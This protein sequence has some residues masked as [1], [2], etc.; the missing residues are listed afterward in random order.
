MNKLNTIL[1]DKLL[2]D[3][4]WKQQGC[5]VFQILYIRE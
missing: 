2:E 4:F 1:D 5:C 3:V